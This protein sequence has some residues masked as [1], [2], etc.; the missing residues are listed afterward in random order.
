[1][2]F[3][4]NRQRKALLELAEDGRR[5]NDIGLTREQAL[6]EAAKPFWRP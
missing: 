2:W 1:M 6:G 4:R 5:L 3:A